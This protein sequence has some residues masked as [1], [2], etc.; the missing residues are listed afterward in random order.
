MFKLKLTQ[1][2]KERTTKNSTGNSVAFSKE[3]FVLK[4][5]H[6]F[7]EII[8]LLLFLALNSTVSFVRI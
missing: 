7:V 8:V 4:Y 5:I 2:S 6:S 3:T 1:K